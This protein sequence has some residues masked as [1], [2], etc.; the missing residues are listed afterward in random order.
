VRAFVT[1]ADGFVGQWLVRALL[2]RADDVSATMRGE[3]PALTTLDPAMSRRVRWHRADIRDRNA[4]AAALAEE[5][6]DA[7]FHLAAQSLAAASFDRPE[8]TIETNVMGTVALLE[9]CH[10][11][12]AG[13]VVLF[14]G[15]SEVY[16]TVDPAELPLKESAPLRPHSPYAASKVAAEA[17]ALQY[18]RTGWQRVVATRSFNHTGPGQSPAFAVPSFAK[19][20]AGAASGEGARVLKVGNLSAQRDFTDVR[21][22][23]EAYRQL[24]ARGASGRVYNVCS[25]RAVSMRQIVDDLLKIAGVDLAIEEDATKLRPVDAPIIYG[26][27]SA[28][29]RDTS[30][31][32]QIPLVRTLTDVYRWFARM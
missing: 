11:A 29:Q 9:A 21:D 18:A 28:V 13:A 5:R 4:L 20:I 27:A 25:G 26:D 15:S 32:P 24:V 10:A 19:Q 1:G 22:V 14:A 3:E 6:P 8:E 12:A 2:D 30:W 23:V 7:V 16:G 31:Q 17:I